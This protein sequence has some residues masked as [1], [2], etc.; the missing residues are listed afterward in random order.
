MLAATSLLLLT[1]AHATNAFPVT[2]IDVTQAQVFAIM[3]GS[4]SP[5]RDSLAT[6]LVLPGLRDFFKTT[7]MKVSP[8]DI[9]TMHGTLP[10]EEVDSNCHHE[11][12]A[13]SPHI[14]GSILDTTYFKWGVSNVSWKGATV[15]ANT[16]VDAVLDTSADIRVKIGRKIFGRCR[17]LAQKTTGVDI[18]SKGKTGL[19]LNLTASNAKIEQN[20]NKTGLELVFHFHADVIGLVIDWDVTNV[21]ASHCKIKIL[22]ITILSY[23]GFLEKMIKNGVNKLSASASRMIVPKLQEKLENAINTKVGAVVRIPLKLH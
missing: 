5:Q 14:S 7:K 11:V 20:A 18:K 23:C 19:G 10:S 2:Q 12:T 6:T 17:K 9:G 3:K 16:E 4:P 21:E 1:L 8:A 15:F 22:G 13:E